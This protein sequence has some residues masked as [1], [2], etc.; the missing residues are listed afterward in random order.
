[1]MRIGKFAK[2]GGVSIKALRFYDQQRILRPAFVD[3]RNGY[4]YYELDQLETLA[5]IT[6]LRAAGFSITEIGPLLDTGASA[7]MHHDAIIERKNALETERAAIDKKLLIV[8]ALARAVE[9]TGGPNSSVF[10]LTSIKA[11][12]VYSRRTKVS[13]LGPPVTELFET[14]EAKVSRETA[15]GDRPPFLIFHDSPDQQSDIDLEICIPLTHDPGPSCAAVRSLSHEFAC[16]AIYA[17]GYDFTSKLYGDMHAWITESGLVPNG[18]LREVYHCFGAD[19][20]DYRLPVHMTVSSP[21]A[22]ITE[23]QLPIDLYTKK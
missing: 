20:Y 6:N 7:S 18:P 22:Y 16:S 14:S 19:E 10:K 9:V 3:G 12:L 13:G 23:L 15:R 21:D 2:L 11:E 4:R 5:A 17:G 8:E 1:M